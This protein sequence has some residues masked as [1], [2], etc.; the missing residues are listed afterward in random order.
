MKNRCILALYKGLN[1]KMLPAVISEFIS[2][3]TKTQRVGEV[4]T[5]RQ[6]GRRTDYTMTQRLSKLMFQQVKITSL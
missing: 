4:D 5:V 6:R 3:Q 1:A 2:G